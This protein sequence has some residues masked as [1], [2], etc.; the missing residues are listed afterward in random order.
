MA[1][2]EKKK[3][4]KA[5]RFSSR[6]LVEGVGTSVGM[7]RSSSGAL[8]ARLSGALSFEEAAGS[9]GGPAT[10]EASRRVK[11]ASSGV[12]TGVPSPL[13]LIYRRLLPEPPWARANTA[14]HS[15]PD[16]DAACLRD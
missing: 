8:S 5:D 1:G 15:A 11:A 4:R 7:L 16:R 10:G 12:R 14:G 13:P 6:F 3:Y 9:E 2:D